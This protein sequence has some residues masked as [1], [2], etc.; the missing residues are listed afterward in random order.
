MSKY[1]FL[2]R[3]QVVVLKYWLNGYTTREIAGRL[4][5]SHQDVAL[6]IKRAVRNIEKAESTLLVYRLL[7]AK[8]KIVL[9]EGTRL[10]D[11]PGIIFEEADRIG[12]R[13]NADFT[14]IFKL[15][16]FKAR[17]CIGDK[18]VKKPVLVLLY[19]DGEV[20]VL[21]LERVS[22]LLIELDSIGVA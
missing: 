13:V 4:G 9:R 10:V 7:S 1:G 5:V 6:T 2:T 19:G 11:V 15:L 17:G 16:R 20:D 14:L 12:V 3:K 22:S 8:S 21:P 18:V